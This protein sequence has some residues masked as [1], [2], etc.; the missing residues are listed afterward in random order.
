MTLAD[1]EIAAPELWELKL[2]LSRCKV[3]FHI[4]QNGIG[5]PAP[6]DDILGNAA[7]SRYKAR[8]AAA[9]EAQ[10]H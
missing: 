8:P 6:P 2:S 1:A 7:S 4:A 10:A 3:L 5:F 9:P